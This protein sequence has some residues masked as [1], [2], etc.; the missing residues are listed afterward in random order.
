MKVFQGIRRNF[1][2]FKRFASQNHP[3]LS[4]KPTDRNLNFATLRNAPRF[5]FS[6][7]EI[8]EL[9]YSYKTS[10]RKQ[11][12]EIL[13]LDID[14][15]GLELVSE[16][17]KER[18]LVADLGYDLNLLEFYEFPYKCTQQM[19]KSKLL[20]LNKNNY[21]LLTPITHISSLNTFS[22]LTQFKPTK[23]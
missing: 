2:K 13:R 9:V 20:F 8:G 11:R 10:Q 18:F 12:A 1:S 17:E 23:F 5:A 22:P 6:N 4:L 16:T 15:N 21:N 19:Q 14:A 7:D 3:F